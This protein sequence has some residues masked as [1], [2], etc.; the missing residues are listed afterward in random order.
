MVEIASISILPPVACR[1]DGG[2]QQIAVQENDGKM[3]IPQ[4]GNSFPEQRD[5]F[6]PIHRVAKIQFR[7]PWGKGRVNAVPVGFLHVPIGIVPVHFRPEKIEHIAKGFYRNIFALGIFRVF[8]TAC[9][10]QKDK[11]RKW[12][13]VCHIM[14]A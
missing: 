5:G 4:I 6:L 9:Q 3:E 10:Q 12:F 8:F 2:I 13:V 11:K 1:I 7:K 14:N